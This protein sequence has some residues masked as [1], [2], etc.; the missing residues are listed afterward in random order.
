MKRLKYFFIYAM[1]HEGCKR[2]RETGRSESVALFPGGDNKTE[3]AGYTP[4]SHGYRSM[5]SLLWICL[6]EEIDRGSESPYERAN[7]GI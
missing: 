4:K 5:V 6:C 1:Q 3:D 7:D 2:M